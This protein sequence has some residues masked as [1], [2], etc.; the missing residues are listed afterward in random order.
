MFKSYKKFILFS[1]LIPLPFII[2]LFTLL[3]IRDP[4][5]FFHKPW[6]RE[7]SFMKDMRMQARGI[8]L[9]KDFDSVIIGTS[10]LENT[11]AKEANEKLGEEWMNLSLGGS[12]FALRSVILEY[13][14]KHKNIKNIIY[15]VDIRALNDFKMPEDKNFI[16]LYND[17]TLNLFKIYLS[18]R[19]VICA[20]T[21]SKKEKCIGKNDLDTLTNWGIQDQKYF[22]GFEKWSK[23]WLESKNFKNEILKA[24]NF[25][26][27]LNIDISDFK[28]YTEKYLLNFIKKHQN[29]QFHLIVPSY[30]RLN[31]RRLSY[32]EYY[33][34]DSKLFSKYYAIVSWLIKETSK[35]PNVKIYGFD[36]LDYADDIRNYKDPAHYNTDMNSMQLDAIK[37]GMHILTPQNMDEYFKIMEEKIR[38]YNLTPFVEFIKKQEN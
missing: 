33:N 7:E 36:D 16:A 21:F 19:F 18:N 9:H 1:L 10:M 25:K 30:S 8:I 4:F 5:W 2:I 14:F 37:N 32:G 23:G 27:N 3:Y 38:N 24:Q 13:L 12:T 17:N 31:Y 22:G 20:L 6:F 35:Y 28:N 34:K 26:P 15:S 11:S 29:T